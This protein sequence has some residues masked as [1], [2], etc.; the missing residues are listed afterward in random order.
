MHSRRVH[1]TVQYL[2]VL[3]AVMTRVIT[4]DR[5]KEMKKGKMM[6]GNAD[7][8]VRKQMM[9]RN[10]DGTVRKKMMKRTAD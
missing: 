2:A 6:T 9:T 10:E 1:N 3:S 8:A 7:A 4:I 5:M